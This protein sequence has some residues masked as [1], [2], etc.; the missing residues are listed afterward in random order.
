MASTNSNAINYFSPAKWVV[1]KVAGEGTHTTWTSA[2]AAASLGDTVMGMPGT[3]TENFTL[4][5]GVNICGFNCEFGTGLGNINNTVINGT[6]TIPSLSQSNVISN[7]GLT[8]NS[9]A[10]LS[11]ST[12]NDI[13]LNNCS[14]YSVSAVPF[15]MTGSAVLYFNN[16]SLIDNYIG[17]IFN[18]SGATNKVFINNS[19]FTNAYTGTTNSTFANSSSL[20]I[21][22]SQFQFGVSFTNTAHFEA[23]NSILE[24]SSLNTTCL[25]TSGTGVNTI[26][27]CVLNTGTASSVNIGSGTTL[28]LFNCVVN[29]SNTNALTGAGTLN[30]GQVT[31]SGTS[32]TINVTTQ[33]AVAVPVAQGGTGVTSP[34]TSGNVLTSSG[35]AW[36]SAAPA[37]PAG[38]ITQY[39]VL[40]G[41]ASSAI[42]SVGP[43]SSG[44][45]LQSGGNSSNP[46]YS[47]ATYPATATGTG[48]ILRADGTNWSAS[49]NTY[50]NTATTGDILIATGTNIIGSLADVAVGQVLTSGGLSTAPSYSSTLPSAVQGNITSVGTLVSGTV[51]TTIVKGSTSGSGP[52][53]GYIGEQISSFVGTGSEVSMGGTSLTATQITSI[54]LTAGIWDISATASCN[55]NG[56][57]VSAATLSINS[58]VANGTQG[59]NYVY[60]FPGVAS[61]YD[62]SGTIP[63]YRV[64]LSGSANYYLIMACTYTVSTPK[65]YGRISATRVG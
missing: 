33:N 5:A 11:I 19:S 48:T 45:V 54:S 29:S 35:S 14:I 38:T 18:V 2:V 8:T 37:A 58:S 52:S 44:Q 43:G 25:T 36:H 22:N 41:A 30:Y 50:P 23:Y 16:C 49:T 9:V 40:V 3:Y 57:T 34:G 12:V 32:T 10:C 65:G 47:T 39:D 21:N 46:A 4:P 51:P 26:Q 6:I 56:A 31:F 63:Q 60:F 13:I 1:S 53:A 64:T 20:I 59:S 62:G 7:L 55:L 17:Q 24:L 15:V 28:N 42:V 61:L 27:N